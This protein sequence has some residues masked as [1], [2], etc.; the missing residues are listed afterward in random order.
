M[1]ERQ[2]VIVLLKDG[3]P[4]RVYGSLKDMCDKNLGFSYHYLK[5]KSKFPYNYQ[6]YDI[7]KIKF[8]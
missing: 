4:I 6:G 7:Y 8:R 3:K 2:N 5:G 1:S